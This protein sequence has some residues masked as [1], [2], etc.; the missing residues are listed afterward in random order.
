MSRMQL[1]NHFAV[2]VMAAM[3]GFLALVVGVE[4]IPNASPATEVK[5]TS[6]HTDYSHGAWYVDGQ[7]VPLDCPEEDSCAVQVID[8]VTWV[9][10]TPA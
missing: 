6:G 5:V 8:D 3:I 2:A 7:R 10:K 4:S 1:L 9:F